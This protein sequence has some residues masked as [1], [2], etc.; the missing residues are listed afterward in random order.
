MEYYISCPWY[1]PLLELWVDH[2]VGQTNPTDSDALK[3]TVTLQL[4]QNQLSFEDTWKR[5]ETMM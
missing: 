1:P 2:P 3:H 5:A 4:M